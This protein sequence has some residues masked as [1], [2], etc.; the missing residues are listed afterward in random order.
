MITAGVRGGRAESE[1]QGKASHQSTEEKGRERILY[2]YYNKISKSY[3]PSQHV[4]VLPR[5]EM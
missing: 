4:N 2:F 1:W 3:E 5:R